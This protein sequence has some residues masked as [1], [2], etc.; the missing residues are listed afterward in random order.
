VPTRR[1]LAVSK[2]IRAAGFEGGWDLRGV[3]DREFTLKLTV[4]ETTDPE[5]VEAFLASEAAAM[6]LKLAEA[7]RDGE[8][9]D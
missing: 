7:A 1:R 2:A 4:L 3:P 8:G 5:V 9:R 6:L